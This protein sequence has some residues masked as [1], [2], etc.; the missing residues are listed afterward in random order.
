M[1]SRSALDGFLL[2]NDSDEVLA[3][4]RPRPLLRTMM[5]MGRRGVRT[6][7]NARRAGRASDLDPARPVL[8]SPPNE[9]G[10]R[11][12]PLTESGNRLSFSIPHTPVQAESADAP[13]PGPDHD[14]IPRSFSI[15]YAPRTDR[16]LVT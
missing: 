9:A 5:T 7:E 2:M 12:C 4:A 1:A 11:R 6:T 3:P 15:R 14:G 8:N 16:T 10:I 13:T